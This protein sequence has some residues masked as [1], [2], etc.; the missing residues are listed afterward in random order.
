MGEL[1]LAA[2]FVALFAG[3]VALGLSAGLAWIGGRLLRDVSHAK[4]ALASSG[5]LPIF[6]ALWTVASFIPD[7][8]CESGPE[9]QGLLILV[10]ILAGLLF[11]AW[12]LGFRINSHILQ[13]KSK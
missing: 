7:G 2:L 11:V 1:I 4:V 8:C 13:A 6:L 3:A 5:A 12:P 10:I 9:A